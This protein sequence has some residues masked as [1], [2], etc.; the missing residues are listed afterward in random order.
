MERLFNVI[1]HE[2]GVNEDL[3]KHAKCS[4]LLEK[5]VPDI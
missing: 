5:Y 4:A 3:I 1:T 2:R